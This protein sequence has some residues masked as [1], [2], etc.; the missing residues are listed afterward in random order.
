MED[1]RSCD[2]DSVKETKGKD[3]FTIINTNARSLCPKINSLVD[4]FEEIGANLGVVTETWLSDGRGLE[5]DVQLFV[6]GTGLGMLYRNCPNNARGYAHGGVA[7]LLL[8]VF[9]SA[10]TLGT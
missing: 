8:L 4:C 1:F 2:D 10:L 7:F 3:I 9:P 5:D 6:L